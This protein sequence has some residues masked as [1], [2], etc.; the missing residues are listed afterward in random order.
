MVSKCLHCFLCPYL[1]VPINI[2]GLMIFNHVLSTSD[3]SA[4]NNINPNVINVNATV[5]TA[6][7]VINVPG[8]IA[9]KFATN[10]TTSVQQRYP[11]HAA[12]SCQSATI[13]TS[14]IVQPTKKV[15]CSSI[16]DPI[17][18]S[19]VKQ[20]TPVVSPIKKTM[21]SGENSRG[22]SDH[23]YSNTNLK[24]PAMDTKSP[25]TSPIRKTKK[26][27]AEAISKSNACY[28]DCEFNLTFSV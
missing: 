27:Q 6:S 22:R 28:H 9:A 15:V 26:Q 18:I 13:T 12:K 25:T 3:L 16:P 17:P 7:N 11:H 2:V 8:Q 20:I 19:P 21:V 23:E 14:N 24:R 5:T 1:V 10:S 4:L